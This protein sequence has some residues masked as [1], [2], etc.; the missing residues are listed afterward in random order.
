MLYTAPTNFYQVTIPTNYH[1]VAAAVPR[2]QTNV[3]KIP[4]VENALR[5][6]MGNI[7][8]LKFSRYNLTA[9]AGAVKLDPQSLPQ[10]TNPVAS[11]PTGEIVNV[12]ADRQ[13]YNAKEQIF[14]ATGNVTVKYLNTELKAD[15]V[16]LNLI[17]KEATAEGNV[18]LQRGDQRLRGSTL[19]YNYGSS[20]GSFS[21]ASGFLDLNNLSSRVNRLPSDLGSRSSIINVFGDSSS[22]TVSKAIS[23]VRFKA[24]KIFLDGDTWTAENLKVTN[25]PYDPPELEIRANKATLTK[26]TPTQ[27]RLDSESPTLVFDQGLTLPVPFNSIVLDRFE[28]SFPVR[29][30]FDRRDGGGFFYQQNFNAYT[31]PNISFQ[32]SPQIFL[33]RGLEGNLLDANILGVVAKLDAILPDSQFFTGRATLSGLNLA[34]AEN[35]LRANIQYS[36]PVL[37][38]HILVA[39]YAYRDRL[40]NGSLGFQDVSNSLGVNLFSPNYVL[41]DSG[42]NFSYQVGAQ[43]IGADSDRSDSQPIVVASLARLQGA[44]ALSRSFPLWRGTA[45]PAERETGLKY[46]PEPVTPSFDAFLGVAGNYAFYSS[47]DYQS[48]LSATVGVVG[49]FGNFAQPYFDYTKINISYTQG[50]VGG[51]S[52]FLFDRIADPQ[53]FTFGIVQQVYGPFRVGI[54]QS[55]NPVSGRIV[56]SNYSLQYDRRTYAIVIRYNPTR[57]IGELVFRISDFNWNDSSNDSSSDVT[58]VTGGLERR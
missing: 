30:G 36:R 6:F 52:P 40:F 47:G 43:Y 38:D 8:S 32:V 13:E 27:D 45:L 9:Q 28:R 54:E 24:D 1:L 5:S 20:K 42:I 55:W 25:D 4:E 51:R 56:D 10:S 11:T 39:Q 31:E 48:Y 58:P 17:T 37:G 16:K 41:G 2:N 14:T 23:R 7:P 26:I 3:S 44:T 49:V 22:A 33:Q 18:F 15:V 29:I 21:N 57:E 50:I 19:S 34:N 35:Q 46:L 12:I 53:V